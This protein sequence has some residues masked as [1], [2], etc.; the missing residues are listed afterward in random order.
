MIGSPTT[1]FTSSA[2]VV[3]LS[4]HN[5]S[6]YY[7]NTRSIKNYTAEIFNN[8]IVFDFDVVA[9]TE[10][11]LDCS[12]FDSEFCPSNFNLFRRDRDFAAADRERGGGVLLAVSDKFSCVPL[13]FDMVSADV[14]VLIDLLGVKIET[15]R[16]TVF[17]L[18]V[19]IPPRLP[20]EEYTKLFEFLSSLKFLINADTLLLGDFNIPG[21]ADFCLRNGRPDNRTN[22]LTNFLN[23]LGMIQYNFVPNADNRLLDL[24]IFNRPCVVNVSDIVLTRVDEHHPPLS[25]VFTHSVSINLNRQILK[26]KS[27]LYNFR[28]ADFPLL[29]QMLFNIDWSFLQLVEDVEECCGLLYE[30][31]YGVFE[32]TV[33][34]FGHSSSRIYPPWFDAGIK[35]N[36]RLKAIHW[37]K[38]KRT[39]D[40][41]VYISFSALRRQI[42]TDVRIAY[43]NY[44]QQV[45]ND[46]LLDP[47][48]FWSFV[49]S[50]RGFTG[51]TRGMRFD[52]SDLTTAEDIVN[53]FSDFFSQS[54][55]APSSDSSTTPP[56]SCHSLLDISSFNEVEVLNAIRR[57]KPKLTTGPDEVPAFVVRDCA[58]IFAY[59]LSIIFN[60][61]LNKCTMP[62]VWKSSKVCPVFKKGDKMDVTNFRPISIIANF[63]KVFELLL[64][65]NIYAKVK[66]IVTPL[67]HGFVKGRSTTTNLVCITQYL[68][69][70]IDRR[71]QADVIYTDFSKAFDRLD[72]TI[73][74]RKLQYFGFSDNLISFFDSYLNHRKQFV[75]YGG[76]RSA[77]YLAT[78][79]VPQG[80][81][82]GPLLFALFIN[83]IVDNLTCQCLLY[84]DDLKLFSTIAT[85]SDCLRLQLNLDALHEWCVENRLDLNVSK[86]NVVSYTT[87]KSTI[88]F[89]YS[90][91][92]T[93]LAR[94]EVF[95]DLGVTFDK[96]LTF[97]PHI[98]DLI[99]CCFKILGFIL[100]TTRD[101]HDIIPLK[102]LFFSLVRSKLEYASVV[103]C[104][105]YGV[106]IDGIES[107]QRKFAKAL[108]FRVDGVYP[109]RG[110]PHDRLL[111]RFSLV[112]LDRRRL[113]LSQIF[114]YKLV[115]NQIISEE[116]MSLL[117]FRVPALNSR[118]NGTFYLEPFRTNMYK[119]S[120]VNWMCSSYNTL[121]N[122]YDIFNCNV[123]T[124]K[125]HFYR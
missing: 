36:I 121:V 56:V 91:D 123:S 24:V 66:N 72:H 95:K 86:C 41:S 10:T 4:D 64:H 63:S 32:A 55:L 11:W 78:S 107:V 113:C 35:R 73:L 109:F 8:L 5:L 51:I 62:T 25:I 110:F 87:K 120:P 108:W 17:I 106:H 44:M 12:V 21:Y 77:D 59:P 46:I 75:T 98:N 14:S 37:R 61:C 18:L 45:E 118:N 33:P 43:R 80:S 53:A 90:I 19:Y 71:L 124:I 85:E 13:D 70:T 27:G 79:G 100:R 52:G 101:F 58:D 67:Q 105:Y 15:G 26:C 31:I 117:N 93:T 96:E 74:L 7:Q 20:P 40:E 125:T 54:F 48:R 49:G 82:L 116:L 122:V 9:L 47:N 119:Y 114:L 29:Y 76:V 111:Q 42:K 99:S 68:M 102:T 89:N 92:G 6:I 81:I 39:G 84:A 115:N 88:T 30:K 60:K 57:I 112:C 2:P 94:P 1:S 23:F 22:T 83:D 38:Y 50:R 16:N 3:G 65:D 97:I 69:E 103:W 34:K 28:K 104:P